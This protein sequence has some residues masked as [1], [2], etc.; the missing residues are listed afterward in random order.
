MNPP[1]IVLL[2]PTAVG[3]TDLSLS[4]CQQFRGE[5][6]SADSRQV[7]RQMEIGTAKPTPT[8]RSTLPHH[9]FDIRNPDETLSIAE[10]QQLGYATID[11]VHARGNV[12]FL[13]GGSV[14]YI[15]AIVEGLRIPEVPPNPALRAELEAVAATGGWEPVFARLQQLDPATAAVIDRKN[16]RRVIRALEIFMATGKPKVEL[17]G[18]DP[19]PY[20]ILMIGLDR[21]RENLYARIDRR[22]DLMMEQGLLAETQA[23]LDAGYDPKLS[24]MSS[25]GYREL[26]AYLNGDLAR[27]E[28]IEKIKT[29][30]HRF[31]RHQ[32]TWFRKME[33]V[34]WFQVETPQDEEI[35]ALIGAFLGE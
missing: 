24:S 17:E 16:T 12:P 10:Y 15:R 22:V 20:R 3:K 13:V 35:E 23:L 7:Y 25:L 33:G 5:V 30:T 6:V 28:A 21:S 8:E 32:Y 11:A 31:V 29:E 18:A 19:P 4:L 1:L 27:D 26:I 34:R 2:G 9:L 14:L